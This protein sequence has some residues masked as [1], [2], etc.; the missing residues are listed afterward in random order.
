[1]ISDNGALAGIA[2]PRFGYQGVGFEKPYRSWP[3][4]CQCHCRHDIVF[5]KAHTASMNSN[6]KRGNSLL[7]AEPRL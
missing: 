7:H 5:P 4:T 1:M 3:R 2:N 6:N